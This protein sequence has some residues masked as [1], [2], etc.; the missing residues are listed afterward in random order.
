MW[1]LKDKNEVLKE[2]KVDALNGLSSEEAKNR[3]LKYGENKLVEKNLK[4]CFSCFWH[5]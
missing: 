2:F 1:F 4:H 5:N 3:L